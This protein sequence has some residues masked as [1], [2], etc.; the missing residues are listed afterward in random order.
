MSDLEE[1]DRP[2][3]PGS[4]LSDRSKDPPCF[5]NEPGPS[6]TKVTGRECTAAPDGHKASPSMSETDLDVSEDRRE[7][8]LSPDGPGPSTSETDLHV[9]EDRREDQ[10][11]PDGPEKLNQQIVFGDP[12][13][14]DTVHFT[15]ELLNKCGQ[16]SYRFRCPGPGVFQCALTGLVFVMTEGA[17]LLYNTVQWDESLLQSA[18][19]MA[20]GPLYDIKCS[21]EAAVCQ[22][23][24]PHCEIIDAPL[25]DGL[26]SV[27][28]LTDDGMSILELLQITDTHVV[29]NVPHLSVF[30]LIWDVLT[31]LWTIPVSG[32]V[33]LFLRQPNPATQ[34]QK[35]NMLLLPRNIPLDTVKA[36]HQQSRNIQV[37]ATCRLIKGQSYTVQCPQA[38]KIQ[39]RKADFEL[40]FGPNYHPTFELRLP[41]NT[42]EVTLRVQD[43][44]QS[45]W[46]HDVD[47]IGPAEV[48]PQRDVSED[49]VPAE[50]SDPP[51]DKL[52][53]VRSQIVK[54]VSDPVLN[55]L[56]D[57]LLEH[58]VITDEEM[59]SVRTQG[60]ADKARD[61]IDTV[62]RK[63]RAASSVLISALCELDPVLSRE[64]RLI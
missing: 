45:I 41:I 44:E 29:V 54:R 50:D 34:R 61:V 24:L 55:Q 26:L 53:L 27:V 39:P 25:P 12:N 15:P 43:E 35:L 1:Q 59:Q 28:H 4:G 36:Q 5:S 64:L 22:L 57:N 18:G 60:R 33:L 58:G 38:V 13:T 19:R 10:L 31:R 37:P 42:P 7:D 47:L 14:N 51:E 63:G 40:E 46:E 48:N 20:A 8:Q 52:L 30:G 62:R 23:H 16:T 6:V 11:S 32:Q 2:D 9:S 49:S 21:E 56:L 17:E 3:S